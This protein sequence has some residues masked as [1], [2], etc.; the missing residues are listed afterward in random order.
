MMASF[1]NFESMFEAPPPDRWKLKS[2]VEGLHELVRDR[3]I[4]VRYKDF[5]EEKYPGGNPSQAKDELILPFR[6]NMTEAEDQELLTWCTASAGEWID[7]VNEH[8]DLLMDK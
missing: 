2:M 6:T 4:S 7:Q 1:E 3:Y 8:I 5:L